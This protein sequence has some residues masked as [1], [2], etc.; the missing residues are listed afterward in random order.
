M[1]SFALWMDER[2][3]SLCLVIFVIEASS[4]IVTLQGTFITGAIKSWAP[5]GEDNFALL[6]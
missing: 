3:I 1:Y 6:V 4:D 5:G 2:F